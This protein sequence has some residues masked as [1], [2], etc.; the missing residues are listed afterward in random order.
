MGRPFGGWLL[1]VVK[2]KAKQEISEKE[3][4]AQWLKVIPFSPL[5]MKYSQLYEILT[6]IVLYL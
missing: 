5:C 6:F 4:S 1:D 3:V 2:P